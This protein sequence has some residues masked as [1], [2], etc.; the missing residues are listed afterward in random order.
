MHTSGVCFACP[1]DPVFKAFSDDLLDKWAYESQRVLSER[2]PV[3]RKYRC[4]VMLM[5]SG[6]V[7]SRFVSHLSCL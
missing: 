3:L 1:S 7:L 5:L 4:H 2:V 6:L